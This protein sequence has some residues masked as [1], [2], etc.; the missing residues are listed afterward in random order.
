MPF[1]HD[2]M[3]LVLAWIKRRFAGCPAC[4]ENDFS[5][6]DLVEMTVAGSIETRKY[7]PCTCV[8]CAY[9]F[10]LDDF[11]LQPDADFRIEPDAFRSGIPGNVVPQ[12][13][14]SLEH[15]TFV[16]GQWTIRGSA[17]AKLLGLLSESDDLSRCDSA[18]LP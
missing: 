8:N 16:F 11:C 1:T 14:I 15:T 4:H 10:F 12:R 18:V 3:Q 9:T 6:Y 17:L 7:I 5:F 2:K 13:T